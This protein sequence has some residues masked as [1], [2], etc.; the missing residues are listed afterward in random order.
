MGIGRDAWSPVN[1]GS[2]HFELFKHYQKRDK[3]GEDT[4]RFG[5]TGGDINIFF[6][7]WSSRR[8]SGDAVKK[9]A[10]NI[11]DRKRGAS[12]TKAAKANTDKF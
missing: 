6:D 7:L 11:A 3:N 1:Q 12:H 10:K 2:K 4:H 5:K 8:I 9:R